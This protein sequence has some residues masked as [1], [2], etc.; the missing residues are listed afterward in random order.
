MST[1]DSQLLEP[2]REIEN[3]LSQLEFEENN[4]NYK[5]MGWGMN[6]SNMHTSRLDKYSVPDTVF[7]PD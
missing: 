2:S 1:V 5:E 3:S 4:Q 7:K 6:S